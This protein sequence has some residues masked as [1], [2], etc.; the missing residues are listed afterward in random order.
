MISQCSNQEMIVAGLNATMSC[1][2][3][4]VGRFTGGGHVNQHCGY[5]IPCLIRRAAVHE[6]GSED[7]T[8]YTW[9][10]L[11]QAMT[12]TRASDLRALRMALDH[13]RKTPP[14]LADLLLAGP[15]PHDSSELAAYV[16]VYRR[17][18]MEIHRFLD[19]RL[20]DGLA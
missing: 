20:S 8:V 14:V 9:E 12:P 11:R 19:T 10:D 3:P 16:D 13:Y 7:P 1:S 2:H 4:G 6:S 5:C 18:V 15:L 17:G